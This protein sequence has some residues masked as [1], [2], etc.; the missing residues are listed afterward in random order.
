MVGVMIRYNRKTGDRIVREFLG[1]N[2]YKD[3]VR[4]KAFLRDASM[5]SPKNDWETVVIGADSLATVEHTHSRY[6]SG[7]DITDTVAQ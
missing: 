3:A 1:E 7:R 4:S 5:L 6:F 2:G